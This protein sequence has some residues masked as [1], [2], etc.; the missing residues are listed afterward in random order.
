[1]AVRFSEDADSGTVYLEQGEPVHAVWDEGFARL[2]DGR[3]EDARAAWE[4]ALRLDPGN[5][6]VELNLR[7]LAGAARSAESGSA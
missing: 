3:R 1:M 5:R 7:K 2:R 6:V 4:E